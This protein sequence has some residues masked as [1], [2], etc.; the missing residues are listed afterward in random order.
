MR[1]ATIDCD[2]TRRLCERIGAFYVF[3][4]IWDKKHSLR[5]KKPCT[6]R[7]I[8]SLKSLRFEYSQL[9]SWPKAILHVL[10]AVGRCMSDAITHEIG[11]K[12]PTFSCVDSQGVIHDSSTYQEQGKS[13]IVYFLQRIQLLAVQSKHAIF[14]TTW[15][16]CHQKTMWCLEFP[17]IL[18]ALIKSSFQN[19]TSISRSSWTEKVNCM[20]SSALGG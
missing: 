10:E 14:A 8:C 20:K 9:K 11:Q 3:Y 13:V 2:D 1:V 7:L 4:P 16:D 17:R 18:K 15:L 19:K 6:E 5:I 12:A